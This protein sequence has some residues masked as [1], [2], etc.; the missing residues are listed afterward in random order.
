MLKIKGNESN[1][2]KIHYWQKVEIVKTNK[3]KENE[4]N[5]EIKN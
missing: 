5:G 4:L 3:M 2:W 1:S